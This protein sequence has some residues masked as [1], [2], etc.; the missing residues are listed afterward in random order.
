MPIKLVF[1]VVVGYLLFLLSSKLY[2]DRERECVQTCQA[3]GL[4]ATYKA[5]EVGRK[6][7]VTRS[8]TCECV[9]AG[10]GTPPDDQ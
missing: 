7:H 5:G 4:E 2:E 1:V 9:E 6:L 10:E 8:G 3:Q